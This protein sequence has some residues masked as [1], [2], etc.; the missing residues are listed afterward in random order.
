MPLA[1][2]V[3]R[4]GDRRGGRARQLREQLELVLAEAVGLLVADGEHAVEPR[5]ELDR[6]VHRP[7]RAARRR[8]GCAAAACAC[9]P[10][11]RR[12]RCRARTSCAASSSGQSTVA[13]VRTS[14]AR[15]FR[16][17]RSAHVAPVTAAACSPRA[18]RPRPGRAS[19]RSP[20]RRASACSSSRARRPS[21]SSRSVRSS[22][23]AARSASASTV[24]SCSLPSRRRPSSE[25]TTSAPSSV[26]EL[27][28]NGAGDQ[29]RGP[30][31]LP[32]LARALLAELRGDRVHQVGCRLPGLHAREQQAAGRAPSCPSRPPS[33]R[34]GPRPRTI[35]SRAVRRLLGVGS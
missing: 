27:A 35:R 22:E 15:E 33:P 6:H 31:G 7:S 24:G 1:L 17:V 34:A 28:P 21:A 11:R 16:R 18:R 14:P 3:D 30:E 10:R 5:P 12:R 13:A 8:R 29:R 20:R 23:I 2:E 4:V 9:A 19:S 32:R 26:A 25:A